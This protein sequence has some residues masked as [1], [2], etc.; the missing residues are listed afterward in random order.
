MRINNGHGYIEKKDSNEHLVLD[1]TDKNKELFKKYS[2]VF[3]GIMSKIRETDDDWFEYS[4]DYM[5]IRFSSDIIY[6]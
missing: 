5:K 3:H 4:K 6:H 1:S 2:D